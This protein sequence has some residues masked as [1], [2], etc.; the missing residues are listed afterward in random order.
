MKQNNYLE[1]DLWIKEYDISIK[2][3]KDNIWK[4]LGIIFFILILIPILLIIY[5]FLYCFFWILF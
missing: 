1:N 2:T 5:F 3:P 4:I